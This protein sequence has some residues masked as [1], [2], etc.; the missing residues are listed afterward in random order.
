[1][2]EAA[3]EAAG[4]SRTGFRGEGSDARG[5]PF[6]S[7]RRK[8]TFF[9]HDFSTSTQRARLRPLEPFFPFLVVVVARPE[10]TRAF[11]RARPRLLFSRLADGAPHASLDAH[12]NMRPAEVAFLLTAFARLTCALGEARTSRV[13]DRAEDPSRPPSCGAYR[14]ASCDAILMSSVLTESTLSFA[15]KCLVAVCLGAVIGAQ[16]EFSPY[17]GMFLVRARR[18]AVA[19]VRRAG[20]RTHVLVALGACLFTE[21]SWS[22]F[23]VPAPAQF[24]NVPFVAGTFNYDSSRVAAQVVSGIGFLGAGTIWRSS[25][26][27][28][29]GSK[30]G[31]AR[32]EV[33][34]LTTAASLWTTAAV[35][36]HC[37]GANQKD[38]YFAGPVFATALVVITLQALVHAELLVH[39]MAFDR[40]T[41]KVG[42]RVTVEA[43]E[44]T[45]FAR[46]KIRDERN[47]DDAFSAET[48]L[49]GSTRASNRFDA[50]QNRFRPGDVMRGVVAAVERRGTLRVA[51]VAASVERG[52]REKSRSTVNDDDD[53]DD[54]DDEEKLASRVQTKVQVSLVVIVPACGGSV[55]LLD[56]LVSCE[57]VTEA[58]VDA[59]G[60]RRDERNGRETRFFFT[61]GESAE[62]ADA[63]AE[64]VAPLL[65]P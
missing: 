18:T 14:G 53:D 34:G 56:A 31:G 43:D 13:S 11:E 35:G 5:A 58:R 25:F 28:G 22:A 1:M 20:L 17:L 52:R 23:A 54:E 26:G 38:K 44:K 36:M 30:S 55:D 15:V 29:D 33:Y 63:D 48:R 57:G 41:T 24:Q 6:Y 50:N 4:R 21:A 65:R 7:F 51:S 45:F 42:A 59:C 64:R 2:V 47:D 62:A 46:G 12:A 37:G 49:D 61:R 16:R 39:A 40:T 32:D 27:T 10:A 60:P 8:R 19:P 3:I 9:G